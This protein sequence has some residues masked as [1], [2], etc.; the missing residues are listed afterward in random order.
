MKARGVKD[1]DPRAP[2]RPNAARIVRIRLDEL[3]GFADGA[4]VSD[5]GAAQHDMRIAAKRLRYVLE[6]VGPCIGEEAKVA[7][8]AAK[9]LQSVLGDLHDCDLMLPKVEPIDS[10]A[11]LLHERR[12]HLFHD[13]AALWQAEASKG[14]WAALE[15]TSRPRSLDLH[16]E[17]PA[18][19]QVFPANSELWR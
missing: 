11:A 3:R 13:F 8:D 6:I 4:L 17:L 14:T 9:Q 1:L 16:R 19:S 7:R 5:A 12:N 15:A 18:R 10:A 2:L